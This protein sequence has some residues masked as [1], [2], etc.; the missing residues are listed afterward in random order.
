MISLTIII[1]VYSQVLL[2]PLL[3]EIPGH[4]TDLRI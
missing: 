3:T 4:A 1:Q 2:A